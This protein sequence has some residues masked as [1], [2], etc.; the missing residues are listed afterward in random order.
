MTV[1]FVLPASWSTLARADLSQLSC[2]A[3]T[4]EQALR[5]LIESHPMFAERVFTE[6]GALAPWTIVCLNHIHILDPS[7]AI[8]DGDHELQ[9]IPALMGG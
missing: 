8:S 6:E 3:S 4:V 9:I 5:W 2:N 7:T 1:R